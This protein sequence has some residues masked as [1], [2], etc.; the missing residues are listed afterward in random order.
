MPNSQYPE[1]HRHNTGTGKRGIVVIKFVVLIRVGH[2]SAW[3]SGGRVLKGFKVFFTKI[4]E[5]IF[6]STQHTWKDR[7]S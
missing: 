2:G 7:K 4:N 5:K 3:L 1:Y 6:D